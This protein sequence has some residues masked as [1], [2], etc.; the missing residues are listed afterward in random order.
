MGGGVSS[1]GLQSD[2]ILVLNNFSSLFVA[3]TNK[4]KGVWWEERN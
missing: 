3:S 1:P 2:K 4:K